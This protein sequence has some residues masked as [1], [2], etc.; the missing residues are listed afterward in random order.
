MHPVCAILQKSFKSLVE[1]KHAGN[2]RKA[3]KYLE[4]DYNVA[5]RIFHGQQKNFVFFDAL[6]LVKILGVSSD[7]SILREYYPQEYK[8]ASSINAD[9]EGIE[10]FFAAWDWA[11][12][13]TLHYEILL[14]CSEIKSLTSELVQSEYGS[15]GSLALKDLIRRKAVQVLEDGTLSTLMSEHHWTPF[16]LAEKQAH[17]NLRLT[18]F[19]VPGSF[20]RNKAVG[21]S[22]EGISEYYRLYR[23]FAAAAE[24]LEKDET[25]SGSELVVS[26]MFMGSVSNNDRA[27]EI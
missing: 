11:M 8:D 10:E 25:Y 21:L 16:M 2:I 3:A 26:G 6:K 4:I 17:A 7:G 20:I 22:N 27:G 12:S 5:Y 1:T 23:E 9:Q 14:H 19:D 24:A 18:R 15:K 13:H